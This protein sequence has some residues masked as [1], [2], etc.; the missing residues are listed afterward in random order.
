M[1]LSLCVDLF[2]RYLHFK[3]T[4][5]GLSAHNDATWHEWKVPPTILERN[6]A[7]RWVGLWPCTTS[8]R[9]QSRPPS[10]RGSVPTP[11]L[12]SSCATFFSSPESSTDERKSGERDNGMKAAPAKWRCVSQEVALTEEEAPRD[13]VGKVWN[14]IFHAAGRMTWEK[15]MEISY[16]TWSV[17]FGDISLCPR[18]PNLIATYSFPQLHL[19]IFLSELGTQEIALV[20][21]RPVRLRRRGLGFSTALCSCFRTVWGSIIQVADYREGCGV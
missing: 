13:A 11:G 7:R 2:L 16:F 10:P 4:R 21:W 12:K 1:T 6:A 3:A 17:C 5:A 18:L 14:S 19:P 9:D 20:L 8:S 15:K